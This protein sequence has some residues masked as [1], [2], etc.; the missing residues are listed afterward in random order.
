M[1]IFSHLDVII[2]IYNPWACTEINSQCN[3]LLSY[4]FLNKSSSYPKLKTADTESVLFLSR[5]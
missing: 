3:Y 2:V 4:F 1:D 5:P